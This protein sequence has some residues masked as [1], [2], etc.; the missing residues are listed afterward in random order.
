[1]NGDPV[2]VV[3]VAPAALDI[4]VTAMLWIPDRTDTSGIPRV[5]APWFHPLG[6]LRDGVTPDAARAELRAIQ[7]RRVD[8][9]PEIASEVPDVRPLSLVWMAASTR[10]SS[11]CCSGACCW[12]WPWPA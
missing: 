2:T 9:Y 1:M 12:C 11:A 7:A 3:G 4:P 6:R 8:R 5:S 10:A